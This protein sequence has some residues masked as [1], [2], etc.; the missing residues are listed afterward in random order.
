[1]TEIF[2]RSWAAGG[3]LEFPS[4][5]VSPPAAS[6]GD[7]ARVLVTLALAIEFDQMIR[8]GVGRQQAGTARLR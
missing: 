1:M 4:I 8:D 7:A 6:K 3:R 5:G 2:D